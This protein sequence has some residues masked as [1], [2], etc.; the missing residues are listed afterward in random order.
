MKTKI[1]KH[2]VISLVI[3]LAASSFFFSCND[4]VNQHTG[5]FTFDSLQVN[6]TAHLFGDTA[7]PAC[8]ININFTYIT[9]SSD[10][11]MKD[12]VNKYLLSMCFGDKYMTMDP[13]N[14]P[15]KYAE[16]YIENYRKDLEPMYKQESVEDSANVSAWY[17][18]YKG[19]EGHVQL[20]SGNL[21]VY[22]ISY[23]EYTGGAHGVY[24]TSY[25]NLQLDTLTPIYLDDLFVPNYKDALTDLLWNQL[26]AD[27]QVTTH[28]ELE[29]MGYTSIGELTPTENFF[30]D[31]DGI[32]FHYN[33]Y[34]IAPYV[35]GA[36]QIK[37]PYD[38]V[39][40]LLNDNTIISQIN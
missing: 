24:M 9:K 1:K 25:L 11:Q 7:K 2:S 10:E 32:T 34:D 21:L 18:Y 17:S 35:M 37:L 26:M 14:A 40:H 13:E 31:S 29:N 23:N 6:Q 5:D 15:D 30:I 27:N 39:R 20:Y 28:E 38:A 4:T 19:M 12:S 36:I 33:I 22:R 3:L 16:T 8:N